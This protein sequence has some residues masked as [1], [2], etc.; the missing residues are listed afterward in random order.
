M[1]SK[2]GDA[3]KDHNFENAPDLRQALNKSAARRIEINVERYQAYLD[4][5][6]LSEAQ[7]ED[8]ISAL[9][10]IMSAFVELGFGIHPVQQACGQL[11]ET[12][13]GEPKNDSDR[14]AAHKADLTQDV[15]QGLDE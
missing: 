6:A 9:W 10:S 3:M 15:N 14:E 4:N 2:K 11:P 1:R 12:L 7:K 13:D 8:I 5:P